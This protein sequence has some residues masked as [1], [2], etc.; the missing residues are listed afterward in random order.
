MGEVPAELSFR[1]APSISDSERMSPQLRQYDVFIETTTQMLATPRLHERLLLALEAISNNFGHRQAA[2]ALINERDAELRVRAAVG[3][4]VD[5]STT[6][7]EMPLDSSA[8]C[9]RVIHDAQPLWIPMQED[10]SSRSLFADMQWQDEVLAV[11]LFGISEIPA[12]PGRDS[13]RT[14]T[15]RLSPA[16]GWV[17]FTS[18]RIAIQ[19]TL[20]LWFSSNDSQSGLV[21]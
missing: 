3:F 19:P 7:V 21:S 14:S 4:D 20:V 16:R 1:A 2:I 18:E 8:T 9:V 5:L 15:G 13:R 10:E 6:R 17:C 12:K 11:P